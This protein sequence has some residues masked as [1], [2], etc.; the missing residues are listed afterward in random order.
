MKNVYGTIQYPAKS[1]TKF[2]HQISQREDSD[3]TNSYKKDQI[4]KVTEQ[5][6]SESEC[7]N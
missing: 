4:S 5:E 6:E 2:M 3:G 1:Q 7:G